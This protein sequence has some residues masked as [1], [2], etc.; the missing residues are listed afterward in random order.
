M[1]EEHLK[2]I[3]D[4]FDYLED[5]KNFEELT[6]GHINDTYLVTSNFGERVIL[7][8]INSGVFKDVPGLI[9][10]KVG[11]SKHLLRKLKHF[12]EEELK[13]RVLTFIATKN[14]IFYYQDIDGYFWNMMVYIEG[15]TTFETVKNEEIAYEA[16]KIFGEFLNLTSDF[17]VGKLIEVIPNFHDMAFRFSQ[18][19]SALK[20]AS[21]QRVEQAKT[22]IN[23]VY[24]LKEE[25]HVLQKLKDAEKIKLTVTHNDT[26]ISNVLFDVNKKG[27]CVI[28]TDTVM[29]GI[30][31]YDFGDAVRT[32]C[33][34][35]A[36]DEKN[37]SL[38][39]FN[40]Q[41]YKAYVK[42]FIEKTNSSLSLL[43]IKYLPLGAKTMVFIMALRFLTDFLNDDIYYKTKYLEHNLDRSKNQFK[44]IES[45]SKQFKEM[46]D[47]NLD[48]F[49]S[50]K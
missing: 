10:N 40:L 29:P 19:D 35:A 14:G 47:Y 32:I 43:E 26:K 5:F 27:L 1:I 23:L 46:E 8:K 17:D 6:S 37:L 38:V 21:E 34:T 36:E 45:I 49:E 15:S 18:F 2:F 9:A 3:Y 12:S 39:S 22:C 24:E 20:E 4:Q 30:I 25:M 7:Q 16:G 13:R 31:H 48:F 28:D 44:L 50:L 41:Y 11:V 42:G 33:N